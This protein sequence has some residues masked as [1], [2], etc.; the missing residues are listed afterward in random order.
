MFRILIRIMGGEDRKY[1]PYFLLLPT[2]LVLGGIIAYPLLKAFYMSFYNHSLIYPEYNFIGFEN[3]RR[4]LTTRVFWR[5]LLNSF[6]WTFSSMGTHLILGMSIALLLNKSFRGRGIIRSLILIPWVIAGVSTAYTWRLMFQPA[7]FINEILQKVGLGA[8]AGNWLGSKRAMLSAIIT[9]S[10]KGFPFWVLMMMAGLQSIP[11]ELYEAAKVD[12]ANTLQQFYFITLPYLKK[13]VAITAILD[14]I[15]TFNFF[16][17]IHILTG[18][19]PGRTTMIVPIYIYN[20]AFEQYSISRACA[21]ATF[22]AIFMIATI[23]VVMPWIKRRQ[24]V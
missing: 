3:Y 8:L 20:I 9:H 22:L 19:G 15:W 1:F 13:I 23:F 6:I 21:V 5:V 4:I 18:G 12:G 17:L 7:G 24:P 11:V 16:G 2:I 10:W 14:F